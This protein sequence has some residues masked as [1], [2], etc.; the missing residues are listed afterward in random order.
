MQPC[1]VAQSQLESIERAILKWKLYI[2]C[3]MILLCCT[4][5]LENTKKHGSCILINRALP[6]I[7]SRAFPIMDS[8]GQTS[9]YCNRATSLIQL[10]LSILS[11][12]LSLS[13]CLSLYPF[14][15][16]DFFSHN[17]HQLSSYTPRWVQ[18]GTPMGTQSFA[19][20]LVSISLQFPYDT[21]T[22]TPSSSMLDRM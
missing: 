18:A 1:K 3:V 21:L 12:R 8:Y 10:L 22:S 13:I 15:V 17:Q 14:L 4:N 6:P 19:H 5:L 11:I 20:C 2:T 16:L 9:I 7:I